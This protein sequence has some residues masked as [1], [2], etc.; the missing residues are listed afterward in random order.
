MI[1]PPLHEWKKEWDSGSL[2][3]DLQHRALLESGNDMISLS[4]EQ[5][6]FEDCMQ[7]LEEFIGL[8]TEHHA[9][10]EQL[11]FEI[12]YPE[13]RQHCKIHQKLLGKILFLKDSYQQQQIK[14]TAF[15]TFLADELAK[16]HF[17]EDDVKY[18]PYTRKG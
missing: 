11:L 12:K 13:Y 3:L 18:Y 15:F 1:M 7:K 8:L 5:A 17:L 6:S 10:E 9:F 14:S 16:G 2:D 4:Q